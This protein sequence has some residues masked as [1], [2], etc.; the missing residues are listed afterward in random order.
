MTVVIESCDCPQLI[1]LD[2]CIN[3]NRKSI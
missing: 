1:R 2:V 3:E